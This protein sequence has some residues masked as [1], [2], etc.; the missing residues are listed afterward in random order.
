MNTADDLRSACRRA[1]DVSPRR[2]PSRVWLAAG[3]VLWLVL[4][5]GSMAA[6]WRYKSTAGARGSTPTS[7]PTASL[8][9]R[10]AGTPILVLF[11]HPQC[12]CTHATLAE[13]QGVLSRPHEQA[14]AVALFAV[15]A[16]S[17]ASWTK[18]SAW[19]IA[20]A[21]SGLHVSKDGDGAEARL[22]GAATSG[23]VV[24]Y[25]GAGN[26]VFSGGITG[27]R[28]HEGDNAGAERLASVLRGRGNAGATTPV[29][30]CALA[31]T[32]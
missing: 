4:V 23:H 8:I 9:H 20:S 15:P 27:A 3:F 19:S 13:L 1:G 12:P 25:D 21:I 26:L 6:L 14:D 5:F 17:D 32:E 30:G 18:S 11:A 24:L 10:R 29:F 7:W 31:R 16:G 22:F 2:R 28:G